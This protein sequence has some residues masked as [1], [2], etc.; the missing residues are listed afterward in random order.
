MK[1]QS[2]V[3]IYHIKTEVDGRGKMRVIKEA[4]YINKG[5]VYPKK[6]KVAEQDAE[7]GPLRN[8]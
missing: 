4:A 3:L 1:Q 6:K 2:K 8:L 7:T 5:K